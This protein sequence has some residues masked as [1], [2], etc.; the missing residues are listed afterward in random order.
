MRN[1]TFILL[2]AAL[3]ALAPLRAS[4]VTPLLAKV[5]ALDLQGKNREALAL[6][7]DAE[8]LAPTDAEVLR[9]VAKQYAEAVLDA[10]GDAAK[11]AAADKS[12]DYAKRAVAAAPKNALARLS[13]AICY[14]RA[15]TVADAKTK[16]AYSKLIK[17]HADAALALDPNNDLTHFVLG[18][19]SYE[20]A[21]LGTLLRAAARVVY[22][23][24][25]SATNQDAVRYLERAVQLNPRRV[26]NHASLGRAYAAVGEKDKARQSFQRA[27][28]L[29]DGD[30]G[31]DIVKRQVREAVAEL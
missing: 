3:A 7:L 1:T 6:I 22:G 5:D 28:S 23:A 29:P 25:P 24:L 26:C 2:T 10:K 13:L 4:E 12:L 27:L 30:K 8:K 16:I 9:R 15:A 14:G 17:E 21:N 19:W 18:S 11:K 31:D 20:I